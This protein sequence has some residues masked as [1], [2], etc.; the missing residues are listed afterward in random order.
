MDEVKLK[1]DE[2]GQG[3]FYIME[4]AEQ[5]GEMAIGI[6]GKNLTAYHTEVVPEAEGK[7][8]AKQLVTAMAA[9]ARQ[10][11]LQV[12]PLCS[13]VHAQLKKHAQEYSDIWKEKA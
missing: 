12:I 10:N 2:K 5:L 8:V 9:Y 3:N 11:K 6:E 7:G 4:G 1:L 13:Y